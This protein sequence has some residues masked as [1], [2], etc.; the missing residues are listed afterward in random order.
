MYLTV[1]KLIFPKSY[2]STVLLIFV[3]ATA[4]AQRSIPEL[5]A[6]ERLLQTPKPSSFGQ[7]GFDTPAPHPFFLPPDD[8][9]HLNN[10]S[11]QRQ[12]QQI[13]DEVDAYIARSMAQKARAQSLID[14]AVREM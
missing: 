4:S 3:L 1:Y 6:I 9:Y 14:E 10:L 11:V 8:F 13:M 2:I 12:N 7:Y 5:E